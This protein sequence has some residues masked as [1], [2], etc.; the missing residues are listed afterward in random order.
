MTNVNSN[1]EKLNV[2]LDITLM[3]LPCDIVA[4]DVV[5]IGGVRD[6]DVKGKLQKHRLDQFGKEIGVLQYIEEFGQKEI[7]A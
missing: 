3:K 7:E 4:L 1:Q 6:L 2:N 5:Y